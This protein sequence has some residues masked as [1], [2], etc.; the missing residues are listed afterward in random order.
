MIDDAK[1]WGTDKKAAEEAKWAKKNAKRHNKDSRLPSR[2][3]K[4]KAFGSHSI[5][6]LPR[7]EA[8]GSQDIEHLFDMI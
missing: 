6:P 8:G 7:S 3:K 5:A 4:S 1:P 2:H